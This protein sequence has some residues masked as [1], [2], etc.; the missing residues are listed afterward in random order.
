MSNPMSTSINNLPAVSA[1]TSANAPPINDPIVTDVL[2]EMEREV[3]TAT[4]KQATHQASFV[5]PQIPQ[6]IPSYP[7]GNQ[8]VP[9]LLPPY[10]KP[11]TQSWI[12]TSKLQTAVVATIIAMLLLLPNVAFI[13]ERIEKVAF[14]QSYETFIRAGVLALV[15]YITMVK[16]KI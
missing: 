8:Q 4:Q 15:L 11:T 5:P 14:L 7:Y 9:M 13:Y 12:D 3:A 10:V 2:A 6:Q 16:L 1:D